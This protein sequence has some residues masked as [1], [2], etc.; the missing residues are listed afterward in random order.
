[1]SSNYPNGFNSGVTVR[2]LPLLNSYSGKIRWVYSG[3]SV[4]TDGSFNRPYLTIDEGIN[5]SAAGDLL[6]VKAGHTETLVA[7]GAITMDVAGVSII[8]LG[9]GNNRPVLTFTPAAASTSNVSWT[10]ANCSFENI[11]CVAGLDAL[12]KPFSITGARPYLDIEWQ[13][14][15]ATVEA[16]TVVLTTA[17][18]DNLHIKLKYLGFTAGNA[19]VAPVKLVG[20]TDGRV[21]IDFHG[22]ASTAVVNFVT[23]LSTNILVTGYV[24]NSGTTDGSKLVVD[25]I[26]SSTWYADIVDGAAGARFTGGS[27]GALAKDDISVVAARLGADADTDPIGALLSGTA[28]ITT[29]PAAAVPANGVNAFE[30]LR[31]IWANQ[32]GTAANENGITTFPAAAAPGNNVSIAEVLRDAWDALRNGTGGTEPGTNKSILDAIGYDGASEIASSAA[33]LRT[34]VGSTFVVKKT[35]TSSAITQAGVDVTAVST[36]G[37]IQI[38]DVTIQADATG[39][40]AGTSFTLECNNT[41]GSAVF[42]STAVS[43]LGANTLMDLDSASVV[44]KTVVLESGKKVVAKCTVADCTGTGTVDVYLVCRR[45]NNGASLAA[46]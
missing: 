8:G 19:C 20:C 22:V 42:L 27:G 24:Y 13:D 31:Q 43:G 39:L 15:S 44:S 32:C 34:G 4:H 11:V 18:A 26:G 10:A 29:M 40:A 16:E 25:T 3:G 28:G 46:A 23:T 30:M 6:L 41:K 37:D 38:I 45:L 9:T 5:A 17:T 7:A 14:G 36:V 1:M 33:M 2:G 12:T 21:E 35:L